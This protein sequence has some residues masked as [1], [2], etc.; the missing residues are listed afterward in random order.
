MKN[1]GELVRSSSYIN[2]QNS[3]SQHVSKIVDLFVAFTYPG[4]AG[5]VL[6]KNYLEIQSHDTNFPG[7]ACSQTP[8]EAACYACSMSV[9]THSQLPKSMPLL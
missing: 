7:G 6:S 8:L 9:L 3:G 1:Q 5:F 4:I 2:D